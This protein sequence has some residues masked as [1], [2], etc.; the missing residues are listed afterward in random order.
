MTG[1]D[2]SYAMQFSHYDPVPANAQEQIIA[3]RKKVTKDG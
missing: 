1:G 2:G 3:K